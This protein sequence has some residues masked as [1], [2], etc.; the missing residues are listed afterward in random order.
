MLCARHTYKAGYKKVANN[1]TPVS[2]YFVKAGCDSDL[3]GAAGQQAETAG[4]RVWDC[5]T[6]E[7]GVYE[8]VS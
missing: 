2:S 3:C 1:A 7:A 6:V 8:Y 5:G 4:Q